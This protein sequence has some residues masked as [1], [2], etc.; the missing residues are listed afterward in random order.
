MEEM[1]A[2][3]L[4][5]PLQGKAFREFWARLMNCAVNYQDDNGAHEEVD[6]IAGVF[7]PSAYVRNRA[8]TIGS[9]Y[10][11]V[12]DPATKQ[13]EKRVKFSA[14]SPEECVGG[15]GFSRAK[16]TRRA[17]GGWKTLRTNGRWE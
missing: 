9:S 4:T 1:W 2:D 5:K 8:D 13:R 11:T 12:A 17:R 15:K 16:E 3:I 14:T 7:K 6:K 10:R